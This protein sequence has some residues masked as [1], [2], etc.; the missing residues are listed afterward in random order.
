VVRSLFTRLRVSMRRKKKPP[1]EKTMPRVF[2][3]DVL[4]VTLFDSGD[5]ILIS[6]EVRENVEL[7]LQELLRTG[8]TLVRKA[9]EVGSN[10]TVTCRIPDIPLGDTHLERLGSRIVVRGR[11]IGPVHAKLTELNNQGARLEGKIRK[12]DEFFVAICNAPA[13]SIKLNA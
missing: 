13:G 3:S 7:V 9:Q 10:W 4:N 8:A 11:A 1:A 5:S 6:G 2:V 12:I